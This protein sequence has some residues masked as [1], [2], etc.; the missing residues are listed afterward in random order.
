MQYSIIA[1]A[2]AKFSLVVSLKRLGA[3]RSLSH[4]AMEAAEEFGVKVVVVSEETGNVSI[5]TNQG[6]HPVKKKFVIERKSR[7]W[8]RSHTL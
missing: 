8:H 3:I 6:K 5:I 4:F 2:G 1:F 7:L